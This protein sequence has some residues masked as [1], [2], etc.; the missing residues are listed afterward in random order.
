M[1]HPDLNLLLA[2][3]ALLQEQNVSRAAA[4]LGLST[5]AMSH[6]LAR[7][8]AQLGDPLLVRAGQ[9]MVA[10]PRAT[11]LRDRVRALAQGALATLAPEPERDPRALD[12]TFRIKAADNALTL[13]GPALDRALAAAPRVTLHVTPVDRDDPTMLRDLTIDLAI[14]VYDYTPYSELPSELRMQRLFEDR[15]VCVARIGHPTI[16]RSLA[17]AQYAALEHVQVVPRG[18][19]GGY[20]D[21]LLARHGL[22]RRIARAV[23]YFLA[24][25]ALVAETDYVLTTSLRLARRLA[26]KLGLRMIAPPRALGLEPFVTLQL[27]HP[28][29]DRDAAHRW[30]REAVLDAARVS[31]RGR[32]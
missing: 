18:Q 3:D 24:A 27:W 21:E 4:R 17:L 32:S 7:L 2:L 19:V 22:R 29:N 5:P 9:R 16:G 26:G 23:P 1:Q 10:T 11:D 12:R 8:R 30:L 25:F 20:V 6:A 13:L 14:G 31:A 15:F 28:R